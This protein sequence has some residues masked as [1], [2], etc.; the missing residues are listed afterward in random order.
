MM[1]RA[2][3]GWLAAGRIRNTHL[4]VDRESRAQPDLRLHKLMLSF[5]IS[6]TI[7][8]RR[9]QAHASFNGR[10]LDRE[11]SR[12]GIS[13]TPEADAISCEWV[14]HQCLCR[15]LCGCACPGLDAHPDS[16]VRWVA[17]GDR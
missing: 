17:V 9:A 12:N 13:L 15:W 3:S 4:T 7:I 14:T 16:Y 5:H 6:S 11:I 10:S 2:T 8:T 1:R